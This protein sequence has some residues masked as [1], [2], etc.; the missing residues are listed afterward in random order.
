MRHGDA[1]REDQ[2]A[3]DGNGEPLCLAFRS[4]FH[5]ENARSVLERGFLDQ[6]INSPAELHATGCGGATWSGCLE[7]GRLLGGER[8]MS[9]KGDKA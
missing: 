6:A 4:L 5:G 2:Q 9:I 1:G 8:E 7:K 3:E